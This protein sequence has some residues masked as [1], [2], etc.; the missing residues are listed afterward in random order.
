MLGSSIDTSTYSYVSGF[1][2]NTETRLF[3]EEI[4]TDWPMGSEGGTNSLPWRSL[5]MSCHL[6]AE[7]W[8]TLKSNALRSVR[9]WFNVMHWCDKNILW[10]HAWFLFPQ[11]SNFEYLMQLN[12]IAGRTYNDVTQV[13][14]LGFMHC[15]AP[16][17]PWAKSTSHYITS[18]H[19]M[20]LLV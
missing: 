20:E 13:C 5:F 9:S 6:C 8:C 15:K 14:M 2:L 16:P 1:D 19:F 7:D 17:Y 4:T 18:V 3:I 10:Q 12:T 11:I